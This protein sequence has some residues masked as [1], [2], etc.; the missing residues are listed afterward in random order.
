[1]RAV[2]QYISLIHILHAFM[3][4]THVYMAAVNVYLKSPVDYPSVNMINVAGV[5]MVKSVSDGIE[6]KID[7]AQDFA[8]WGG[9]HAQ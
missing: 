9:C 2:Y 4:S 1:M 6:Q 5:T 8:S 7:S 3:A